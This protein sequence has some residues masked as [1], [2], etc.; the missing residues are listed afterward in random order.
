MN[1]N[2]RIKGNSSLH[3]STVGR[4]S[5]YLYGMRFGK[6]VVKKIFDY[7]KNTIRWVCICDC[8]KTR[9]VAMPDLKKGKITH[10]GYCPL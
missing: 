2:S 1:S 8:G 4:L 3:V 5:D 6:L 9:V 10:C 7:N